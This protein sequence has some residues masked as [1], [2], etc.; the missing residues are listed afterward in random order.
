MERYARG[1]ADLAPA[2]TKD[3]TCDTL[4]NRILLSILAWITPFVSS[5]VLLDKVH[6]LRESLCG[7]RV[8]E[9]KPGVI[10]ET[11]GVS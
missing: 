9:K 5:S 1:A 2:A 3:P 6:F 10:A 8:I 7:I 11:V 4:E